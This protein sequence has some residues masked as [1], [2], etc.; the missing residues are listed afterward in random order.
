MCLL[1]QAHKLSYAGPVN[2]SGT[3]LDCLPWTLLPTL[4]WIMW[5][6]MKFPEQNL[7]AAKNYCRN[8][9]DDNYPICFVEYNKWLYC[10]DVQDCGKYL[11]LV[12]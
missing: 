4:D 2:V 8:F 1:Q 5:D 6:V 7:S 10:T 11:T 9:D 3:G 12:L